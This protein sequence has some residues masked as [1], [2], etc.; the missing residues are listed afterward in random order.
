[1]TSRSFYASLP[2]VRDF[3]SLT[4]PSVFVPLP[5]DWLLCCTDIVDST[6]LVAA[7]QY[8]TVNMIGAAVIAAMRNALQREAFP[9][10]F[11]GDGAAFAVPPCHRDQAQQ[12]LAA[13]R[14][15]TSTEFGVTLRAALLPLTD[16]R[17]TGR[18]VRVARYA[19][20]E[21]ADFGM[22]SG[23]GL[24]WAESRMKAGAFAVPDAPRVPPPD[25][26][27]LSCRWSSTPARN[28]IILSLLVQPRPDADPQDFA[29]LS[30]QLLELAGELGNNGHPIPPT[31][32]RLRFP[33]AGH[34]I[35]AKAMNP[36]IP[37]IFRK[38]YLF[39]HIAFSGFLMASKWR[40]GRFDP[41]H[42]LSMLRANS[43]FRKFDDG[44]KMTLDCTPA[45][46]DRIRQRLQ[47]AADNGLIQF[48]LHEQDAALLTCIVPSAV[49]DD[50]VHF[51]DGA[52][53][54]YTQAA[55]N[56]AATFAADDSAALGGSTG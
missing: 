29:Q 45:V 11:G 1:M 41:V 40:V 32:P 28:G 4:D 36:R 43:D 50:H 3:A 49:A 19:V 31:G 38:F 52:S 18:D 16:I 34:S 12:V 56:M 51:V 30:R 24:A 53:G 35:E 37:L 21:H 7:G 22:F 6:G 27:G 44:L 46:R 20:S 48:G 26:S 42:Y 47:Q 14:N 33:T 8:K 5:S 55:A 23:G 9:Y 15:W 2:P 54:G 17:A 39:F 25:L 13:L 10:I